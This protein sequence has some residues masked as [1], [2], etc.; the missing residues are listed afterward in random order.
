MIL[1]FTKI[2]TPPNF[3][4]PTVDC[5]TNIPIIKITDVGLPNLISTVFSVNADY[6][7]LNNDELNNYKCVWN[8]NETDNSCCDIRFSNQNNDSL[9][10]T[11]K[12]QGEFCRTMLVLQNKSTNKVRDRLIMLSI[13]IVS[14][15]N[16]I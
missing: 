12:L 14:V 8:V 16:V 13:Y 9:H 1:L 15:I 2:C 6:R 7:T 11:A 5:S 10:G 3:F 4:F